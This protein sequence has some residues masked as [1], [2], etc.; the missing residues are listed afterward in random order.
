MACHKSLCTN[1]SNSPK[2]DIPTEVYIKRLQLLVL[3]MFDP[4]LLQ[5]LID[6]FAL[7]KQQIID[8]KLLPCTCVNKTCLWKGITQLDIPLT[9]EMIDQNILVPNCKCQKC[10]DMVTYCQQ[11]ADLRIQIDQC[12][13]STYS[14]D[15]SI[16]KYKSC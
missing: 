14:T 12:I 13:Q 15:F 6:Q 3:Y 1:G 8:L 10:I 4:I 7:L 9:F 11:F 16:L 2:I 5:T